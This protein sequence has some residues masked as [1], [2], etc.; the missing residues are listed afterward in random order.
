M[1]SGSGRIAPDKWDLARLGSSFGDAGQATWAQTFAARTFG[2]AL[3]EQPEFAE[4]VHAMRSGLASPHELA[5]RYVRRDQGGRRV[6][7]VRVFLEV[8]RS[9]EPYRN[10]AL[11][12]AAVLNVGNRAWSVDGPRQAGQPRRNLRPEAVA[13]IEYGAIRV[14]RR[15]VGRCAHPDCCNWRGARL[16]ADTSSDHCGQHAFLDRRPRRFVEVDRPFWRALLPL[17]LD[18]RWGDSAPDW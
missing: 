7:A 6:E 4:Q 15:G 11:A 13:A 5:R 1:P 16:A 12:K 2:S 14:A 18:G 9:A 10:E 3:I 8:A 17:V